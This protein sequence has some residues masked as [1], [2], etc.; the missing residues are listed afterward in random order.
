MSRVSRVFGKNDLN[1]GLEPT[2]SFSSGPILFN[3]LDKSA[4]TNSTNGCQKHRETSVVYTHPSG[5]IKRRRGLP[6][7]CITP[8]S[9]LLALLCF[10][11][12]RSIR[13]DSLGP[14]LNS[15]HVLSSS[16][17]K[18]QTTSVSQGRDVRN[19]YTACKKLHQFTRRLRAT[20]SRQSARTLPVVRHMSP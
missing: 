9:Y 16:T 13:R 20:H 5:A 3:Q 15:P 2:T 10:L 7:L 1:L 8:H 14:G 4:L 12:D 19:Q 6:D 18:G 11:R 17:R